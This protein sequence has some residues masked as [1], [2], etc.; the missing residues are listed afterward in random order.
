M[1]IKEA[2]LTL[3]ESWEEKFQAMKK[4]HAEEQED[5]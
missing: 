3:E 1:E 2:R 4:V 5:K